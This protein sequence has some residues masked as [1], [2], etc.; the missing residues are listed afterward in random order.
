MEY[1]WFLLQNAFYLKEFLMATFK[2]EYVKG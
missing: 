2:V 1:F